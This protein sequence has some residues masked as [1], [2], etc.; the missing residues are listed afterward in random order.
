MALADTG[1]GLTYSLSQ[2]TV[3]RAR[4]EVAV[5]TMARDVFQEDAGTANHAARLALANKVVASPAGYAA[6][7]SLGV[8]VQRGDGTQGTDGDLY[9]AVSFLWNLYLDA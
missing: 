8:A 2:D 4:V 7:F 6:T 1:Y 3:F 5:V 9:S